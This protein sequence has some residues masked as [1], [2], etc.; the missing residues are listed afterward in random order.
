MQQQTS[1]TSSGIPF[2]QAGFAALPDC[3]DYAS[4]GRSGITLYSGRGS[5][6]ELLSYHNLKAESVCMARK[7][8]RAG[9]RPGD[10]V[11]MVAETD[12]DFIRLFF[13]CQ[14][15]ALVPATLPL[16]LAFGDRRKYVEHIRGMIETVN[17]AAA[18]APASLCATLA[19]A[20]E[21]LDL[22]I[23][24]SVG[25]LA[26]LPEEGP[27]LPSVGPDSLAYLQFTSGST[28]FPRAVA[29]TQKALMSNIAGIA[30]HGLN[31][32]AGDRCFSWLPFYH[33]MGLVGFLLVPVA[34]Q[35]S[36]DLLP[37]RE[38]A[39]RP[40]VWPTLVSQNGGTLSFSPSFGYDLAARRA[41]T[42]TLEKLDLSQWRVAG[43][44]GDMIRPKVLERFAAAFRDHGFKSTA[45]VASY[46]MAEATLAVSF[47]PL[48][49]GLAVDRLDVR[50]LENEGLAA[51]PAAESSREGE[52]ARDFVRCGR[53]LPGHQW[54]IRDNKG[55]LLPDGHIGRV[56]LKGPSLMQEYYRE[57][58]ATMAVMT[59]DGWLETGDLGY[60][61]E[62]EVVIT[63]RVKDLI[64]VNGRNIAPQDLEW[65]V[66]REI[67]GVRNGDTA[68][69]S[70]DEEDGERVIVLVEC[71]LS[72]EA[73][74]ETL[75]AEVE[76]VVRQVH[77]VDCTPV[78]VPHNSLPH[79][80]SGKLSRSRAR[81]L[82]QERRF[83]PVDAAEAA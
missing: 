71:R 46:G 44:G 81:Q 75:R 10:R 18:F 7:L 29:V 1:S 41:E 80:S 56:F 8:L 55:N 53:I 15:A 20:V 52:H 79:T 17:A 19:D 9:L 83:S 60:L 33:D 30:Q 21:G 73:D 64:V 31:I 34:T 63:G 47:A 39:R 42:A 22:V 16:P 70:I 11:A 49:S 66:E 35:M 25:D 38:F 67:A 2:R 50:R 65:T 74:R 69:F 62:A 82:Y 76:A 12:G 77:G 24:G 51:P 23:S 45:F 13:A 72:A 14:Y 43:I 27:D 36:L 37:T 57:P 26:S 68:A 78:L 3:L 4:R 61:T 32:G 48:R 59:E 54:E 28:R 40:L 5:V 6:T 58:D